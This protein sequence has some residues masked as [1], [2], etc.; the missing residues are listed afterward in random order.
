MD[1]KQNRPATAADP[2][3][4]IQTQKDPSDSSLLYRMA[5]RTMLEDLETAKKKAELATPAI[6]SAKPA[7]PGATTLPSPTIIPVPLPP[8]SLASSVKIASIL[9]APTAP[10]IKAT[11]LP[12][13]PPTK[14]ES[15]KI[16]TP[17]PPTTK[18]TEETKDELTKTIEEIVAGKT[19]EKM[20]G[21]AKI[22]KETEIKP[23][24]AALKIK[25]DEQK[26]KENAQKVKEEEKKK[27]EA[28]ALRIKEEKQ[29]AKEEQ[30]TAQQA[31]REEV[32]KRAEEEKI[33]KE[34]AKKTARELKLAEETE[35]KETIKK[36]QE[37]LNQ[38]L[39]QIQ[40]DYEAGAYEA[41]LELAQ[42]ILANES[43]SW[44]QKIKVG[45]LIKNA[46]SG[47]RK[48]QINQI[49]E[50]TR[51][52]DQ[53]NL[54]KIV[55]SL[56]SSMPPSDVQRA[57]VPPPAN[58]PTLPDSVE[59][60]ENLSTQTSPQENHV[61]SPRT[62]S[63]LLTEL[64]SEIPAES[65]SEESGP[66]LLQNKR[67]LFIGASVA[68]VI[69]LVGFGVWFANKD[70]GSPA[71][72]SPSII[73]TISATPTPSRPAPDPLFATDKQE[74]ITLKNGELTIKEGL[75]AFA[76]TEEPVGTF[77]ALD[78][79]NNEGKALS[80]KEIAQDLN[81]EIF[82][83]PTQDCSQ[84]G[85]DCLGSKTLEDLVDLN[86]F[87]LFVY[88]Q[89]SSSANT[90]SPFAATAS[91]TNEGRLGLIISLKKQTGSTSTQSIEGQ[92][93][94]SLKDLET[95][96]PREFAS[97]LLKT[98]VIPQIPAFSQAS[99]RDIAIRYLNLP[100]PDI[101]IDYAIFEGKL[102]FATSKES[103]FTIIDQLTPTSQAGERL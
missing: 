44:F 78:I 31:T 79:R 24:G 64:I 90:S 93:A 102:I 28:E 95:F 15:L 100:T 101:A 16:V 69:I 48:K 84:D 14:I 76:K 88:S 71:I 96:L 70:T 60:I 17:T 6:L 82:S 56:P 72:I 9:A 35:K 40:I 43:I 65:E 92:L 103:M 41:I 87:S 34:L 66:N 77:T 89:N 98:S 25:E 55:A 37:E 47:L 63:P 22:T 58:L 2:K 13:S 42:K 61:P 75:L 19:P 53:E 10:S 97:F 91:S 21:E 54:K 32:R 39:E 83:M 18:I 3:T 11:A 29:K 73:P 5:V 4:N 67:V 38:D 1:I 7:I 33:A 8:A 68:L 46:N 49:K 26:S 81:L 20:I 94:N 80:L 45:Q 57:T 74:T 27:K 51:I 99:Y 36:Q 12:P 85:G 23:E 59:K 50:A 62:I 86:T 30:K 52:K